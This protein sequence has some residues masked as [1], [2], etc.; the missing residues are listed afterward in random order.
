[1]LMKNESKYRAIA[2][3]SD[4][5]IDLFEVAL[6][7]SEEINDSISRDAVTK[8]LARLAE[9]VTTAIDEG[10]G[11]S[12]K[13]EVMR[14][15][16]FEL[17]GFSGNRDDYYNPANSDI[18]S[19]MSSKTGI[20]ISLALVQRELAS[21]LG[22]DLIGLNAPGHF[23]LQSSEE[24]DLIIDPFSGDL[25][26]EVECRLLLSDLVPEDAPL[27]DYLPRANNREFVVRMLGNLKHVFMLDEDLEKALVFADIILIFMPEDPAALRDRG[28]IR[29]GLEQFYGAKEDLERYLELAPEDPFAPAI[30]EKLDD[31]NAHIKGFH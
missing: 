1:M 17:E 13:L 6:L 3:L 2:A 18:A 9:R 26:S 15:T 29:Q 4:D 23:L 21:R 27:E 5:E 14:N 31:L 30:A 7:Y 19:V 16:L 8:E 10:M 24:P 28:L 25:L 20:P 12:E 22:I 11:L